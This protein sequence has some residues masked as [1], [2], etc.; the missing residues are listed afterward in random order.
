MESIIYNRQRIYTPSNWYWTGPLG[1]FSSASNTIV[2]IADTNYC[3]WIATGNMATPWPK[4]IGTREQTAAALDEVLIAAGLPMSGL[5]VAGKEQLL[6]Y[7][8]DKQAKVFESGAIF[9]VGTT[10]DPV[11]ILCDGT[12]ETSGRLALLLAWGQVNLT[13]TDTWKDNNRVFTP[14]T[15]AQF[16]TLATLAGAWIKNIYAFEGD[17]ET[18]INSG[19][20]ITTAQIDALVWPTS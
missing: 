3:E 8:E 11:S 9:N 15:G 6:A 14:L 12:G 19:T 4:D 5:V 2:D 16:V 20:I 13:A 1:I 7:G 17:I 10:T 18:E